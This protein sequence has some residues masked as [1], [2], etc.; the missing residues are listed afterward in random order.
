MIV[1]HATVPHRSADRKTKG[2]LTLTELLHISASQCQLGE[3]PLWSDGRLYWCDINLMRL[4]ACAVD[5]SQA[6]F[7]Q[8]DERI[9]ALGRLPEGRL[10]I[11]SEK[12]LFSYD[13]ATGSRQHVADLEADNPAT[14]SND[15][16][17]DRQGGF[18]IG[19]M[20]LTGRPGDGAFYRFFEGE[21]RLLIPNADIPNAQCFAPDGKAAY[22]ADTPSGKI[23]RWHLDAQG[24]PI[25]SPEV[26]LDFTA[27]GLRPDGA[28]IDSAGGLWC[29]FYGAG[30]V[31]RFDPDGSKTDHVE[32]PAAQTTCPAFGGDDLRTIFVT[33]ARQNLSDQ[34]L[35]KQPLAGDIF[36]FRCEIPG[37]LEP[38]VDA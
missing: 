28:I 4:H 9:S 16:R 21:I 37:L 1:W 5:G 3:G 7:V 25:G 8:F 26:H 19:T 27:E 17:A 2:Y 6:K 32:I 10:L 29:A 35:K 20:G 34:A 13:P 31:A 38:F 36:A 23:M 24:W 15:G 12:A 22:L 33:T 11:A 14:R 30:A 18:W